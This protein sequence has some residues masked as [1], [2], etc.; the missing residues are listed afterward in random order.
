[1]SIEY[2]ERLA[3]VGIEPSVSSISDSYDT[4]W[5]RRSTAFARPR[6]LHRRLLE[7]IGNIP[8][9]EAEDQYHAGADNIAMAA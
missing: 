2:T 9:A 1:V 3:E 5:P 6:S 7:P 8:P 4:A